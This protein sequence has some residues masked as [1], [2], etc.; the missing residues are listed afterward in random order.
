MRSHASVLALILFFA[1][2]GSANPGCVPEELFDGLPQAPADLFRLLEKAKGG[3]PEAQ[4]RIGLA[5]DTG[6]GVK[7]DHSQAADWYRKAANSGH[8]GA[9]NNLAGL[10][11]RGLGVPQSDVE[12]FRWY[13]RAAAVRYPPA[14]NNLG[15]LYAEGRGVSRNDET[16][17]LWYRKAASRDYPGAETNLGFMYSVGRGVPRDAAQ[18]MKWYHKAVKKDF[19][20]AELELGQMYFHGTGVPQDF[21]EAIG[22]F[23]K[24]AAH[25]SASA[26]TQLGF[27]FSTAGVSKKTTA[28]PRSG[29]AWRLQVPPWPATTS[30]LCT[31]ESM[32]I[33]ARV[34]AR[35]RN[36]RQARLPSGRTTTDQSVLDD[37]LRSGGFSFLD[38]KGPHQ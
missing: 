2:R 31:R 14:Q 25:G 19:A 7:R 11:S 10:Y 1:V 15:F 4:F 3:D 5:Y 22:W 24:A 6:I 26:Q 18:A 33:P 13:M 17:V 23:R 9:Q 36:R 12:A 29:M 30:Q 16:A 27:A 35:S 37:G 38:R 28:K 32:E 8:P 21:S 20:L 34:R